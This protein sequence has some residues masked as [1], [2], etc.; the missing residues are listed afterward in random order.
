MNLSNTRVVL[1][2]LAA[3]AALA[4]PATAAAQS[5]PFPTSA[6]YAQGFVPGAATAAAVQSS[7]ANWKSKYLKNDCGSTYYRV[8]NATNTASTFSEGQGYGMVLTAYFG[9]KAAFDGLWAFAKKNYGTSNLMGWHVTCS[10]FTTGDGGQ[11]SASDGDEDIGF[12]LIVASVQWGGTY[13]ADAKTYLANMKNV[14]FTTCSGTGR[15]VVTAGSWQGNAACTTSGGGSNTSYWMPAYYRVFHTFTGDSSWGKVADDVVTLYGL[16]ANGTTGIIVNEVDQNGAAVANQTYD[17][18]SCRI[19]WRA[20]LDYLWYGTPAVQSGLTKLSTWANGVG[21]KNVVDGY[22]ANGTPS[23]GT[24]YAGLNEF[25]GGFAVG[26]MADSQALANSF[27]TYFVSIA[28]DNGTYYGSSLRT[29]Y[30]LAASGYQWNPVGAADA[31]AAPSSGG[32]TSSGGS[33][34]GGAGGSSGAVGG[35]SSGGGGGLDAGGGSAS[36][37][38][39]TMGGGTGATS[40]DGGGNHAGAS[41]SGGGCGCRLVTRH[42]RG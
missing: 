20:A 8:D 40:L 21:I 11:N 28:D 4:V 30:L 14:D 19:P 10:G 37:G 1:G 32:G 38:L 24:R 41:G 35:T 2:S 13:A 26:A 5:R 6:H 22:N 3:A 36:G 29:L 15:T 25:V 27:G 12:A 16:A 33:S 18:N 7:Y 17:Y 39:Q 34:S 23:S 42:E 31:G 9:D